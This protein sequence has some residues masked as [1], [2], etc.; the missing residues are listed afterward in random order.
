MCVFSRQTICGKGRE[1]KERGEEGLKGRDV[2]VW[3][4]G[5]G[6]EGGSGDEGCIGDITEK[7]FDM[8]SAYEHSSRRA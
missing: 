7:V 5:K 8:S 1:K 3:G 2:C 6:G 4:G